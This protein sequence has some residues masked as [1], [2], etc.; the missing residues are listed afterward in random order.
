MNFS[1]R[2]AA[3]NVNYIKMLGRKFKKLI[4]QAGI[5]DTDTHTGGAG[6]GGPASRLY[7]LLFELLNYLNKSQQPQWLGRLQ[8]PCV[9]SALFEDFAAQRRPD[10]HRTVS[11]P[12]F[13]AGAAWWS[14]TGRHASP[15][16]PRAWRVP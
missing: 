15:A 10:V 11:Y 8:R 4:I 14:L 2:R 13:R 3:G 7:R 5:P 1:C 12:L 6:C 9:F 16:V